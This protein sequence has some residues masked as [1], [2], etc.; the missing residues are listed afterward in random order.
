MRATSPSCARSTPAG[1]PDGHRVVRNA[2]GARSPARMPRARRAQCRHA[3]QRGLRALPASPISRRLEGP[4]RMTRAIASTARWPGSTAPARWSPAPRR[5]S[6]RGRACSSRARTR[7]PRARSRLHV[8]DVDGNEYVDYIMGLASIT[9]GY[10][11]PAVTEAV[12]R[13]LERGS[14]FSLPHPLEVEVSERLH[15]DHPVRRDGALREDGL[16]G[17]RRRGARGA[18]RHG[19]RRGRCS[20][21]TTAG[22]NGT[23]S[24]RRA[25]RAFRRTSRGSSRRSTTT[26][27]PRSSARSTSITAA[28]PR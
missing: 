25:R 8:W 2:R 26:T 7:V 5:R 11:Y 1:S 4:S 13:Q 20:R 23:R 18:R 3:A 6:A 24:P 9:L 28:S 10:A 17:R 15:R 22:M 19:P 21:V 16:G 14:I 12:A 27:S